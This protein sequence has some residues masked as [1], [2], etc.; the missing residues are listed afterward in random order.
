MTRRL[1]APLA[2][3]RRA[4]LAH[5]DLIALAVIV[6]AGAALRVAFYSRAPAFLHGD[7]I[8]YYVPAHALMAGEGFPLSLKR[9]PVYPVLLALVGRG[10][11]EGFW[12]PI[13][14][15]HVLGV[16]TAALVYGIGRLTFGRGVGLLAGLVA[17]LSGGL[18]IYEHY[19]LTEAVFTF[20]LSLSLL[21]G[22][23]GL[24][25]DSAWCYVGSGVAIGLA[26]LTRPHGQLLILLGPPVFLLCYRRWRPAL[27]AT[28]LV[29]AA[30]ALVMVPWM[31]RNWVVHGAFTVAGALG[32][33]LIAHTAVFHNGQFVFYDQDNPP[34]DRGSKRAQARKIIQDRADDKAEDPSLE[35]WGISIHQR[36]MR[37]LRIGE[38]EADGLMRDAALEAIRARP[39][40][41]A[42][43]V[44][45][46]AVRI[47]VGTP[48]DL[49]TH[50]TWDARY[51]PRGLRYLVGSATAE[52]E[53]GLAV[54]ES[55]VS[56]YQSPRLGP[57][58]P[59]LFLVGLAGS[60]AVPA[61]RPALLVGLTVLGLHLASAATVGFVPR[62]HHPM[63][64][65]M[66][67]V[68]FG[69]VLYLARLLAG[70]ALGRRRAAGLGRSEAAAPVS[71]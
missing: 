19:L 1:P 54:A 18:L 2:A 10:F 69:G 71:R 35:L 65:L 5:P 70:A 26:T 55:L 4:L 12:A 8:Q 68:A 20:L 67:V 57:L 36:L 46:D 3:G 21:L 7:S 29:T 60:V 6:A 48:Q 34:A 41:Y 17:A 59:V 16:G 66:H 58:V 14:L 31:A 40:T 61:W 30:A 63:T 53:Q 47:F 51:W 44:L 9:P 25:R 56:V 39:L 38:A 32:Q 13:A 24:R 42:R 11:G 62:Y 37:Q 52:Q 43:A 49:Q 50:W 23:A 45:D 28:A 27:R 33:N 64:P 22:L 15:Q